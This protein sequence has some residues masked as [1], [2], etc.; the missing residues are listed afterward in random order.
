[1]SKR[2]K[3]MSAAQAIEA[4]EGAANAL[5]QR[6]GKGFWFCSVVQLERGHV[7]YT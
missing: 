4:G 3:K 6:E 1:M 2:T 5:G 7:M